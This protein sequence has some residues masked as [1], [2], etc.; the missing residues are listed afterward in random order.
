MYKSVGIRDARHSL[1]LGLSMWRL[2]WITFIF[3]PLTFIGGF[4]GMNV[5]AFQPSG[6]GYPSIKWYFV[7][8]VPLMCLVVVLYFTF[9]RADRFDGRHDPVQR[10]AYEHIFQD[11]AAS[12]PELW[13]R[14]GPRPGVRPRG[15]RAAA[16]WRLLSFWFDPR[17]TVAARPLS[18]VDEMGLWARAKRRVARRWLAQLQAAAAGPDILA[19]ETGR[20]ADFGTVRGLRSAVPVA[21]ADGGPAVAV[22]LRAPL[23]ARADA[24]RSRAP[25][26]RSH[27]SGSRRGGEAA[28]R[29]GSGGGASPM[30]DEERSSD[31][32]SVDRAR[33][34]RS[35]GSLI[36][37]EPLGPSGSEDRPPAEAA[38]TGVEQPAQTPSSRT[39]DSHVMHLGV[40]MNVRRGEEHAPP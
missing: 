32:D 19:A 10:G 30:V 34:A 18:D 5:D 38:A 24:S 16:Q 33:R 23:P 9:K 39:D 20:A 1:Q 35:A 6:T 8:A 7:A 12:F 14:A 31:D 40:P 15:L 17:R 37:L 29:P 28:G 21:L 13:T 11:F 26:R 2:S 27:S 25:R 3:L 4:F 22:A 36:P